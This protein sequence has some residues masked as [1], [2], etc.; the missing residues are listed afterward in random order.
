M[1]LFSVLNL[2]KDLVEF[3]TIVI[4]LGKERRHLMCKVPQFISLG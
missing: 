2:H 3:E 1:A 4:H